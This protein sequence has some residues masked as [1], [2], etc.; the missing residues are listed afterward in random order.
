MKPGRPARCD[1]EYE[2]KGT[3]NLFMLF[4]PLEGWRLRTVRTT[5]ESRLMVMR[6]N[7]SVGGDSGGR[8]TGVGRSHDRR[9]SD[10]AAMGSDWLEA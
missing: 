6:R 7:N 1:Y 3:A 8:G 5:I 9:R 4:A 2:R 10:S